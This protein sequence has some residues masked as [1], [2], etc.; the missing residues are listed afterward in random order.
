MYHQLTRSINEGFIAFAEFATN[1]I[2]LK[3]IVKVIDAVTEAFRLKEVV[4]VRIT[5]TKFLLSAITVRVYSL[6][7]T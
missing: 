6:L 2:V 1:F 7:A 4:I 3:A 5:T